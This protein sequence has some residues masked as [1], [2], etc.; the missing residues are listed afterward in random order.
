MNSDHK[1]PK[2]QVDLTYF[3]GQNLPW[4]HP[5]WVRMGTFKPAELHS[6]WIACYVIRRVNTDDYATST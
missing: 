1:P 5:E 4:N 6:P 3:T 2:N